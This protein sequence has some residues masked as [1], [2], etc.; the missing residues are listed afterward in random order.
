M[1]RAGIVALVLVFGIL[2]A[3][4]SQAQS[5]SAATPKFEVA[6]IRVCGADAPAGRGGGG[7]SARDPGMLRIGCQ[8]VEN[9]IRQ[10]YLSNGTPNIS[11]RFL[12]QPIKGDAW[13]SSDRYT[14][15]A[16]PEGT[17]TMGMMRGPMMRA[18]LEDRFKLKIHRETREIPVYELTVAKGGPKLQV[19]QPGKCFILDRDHPLV[20]PEPGKREIPFCGGLSRVVHSGSASYAAWYGAT[21]ADLCHG[22]SIMLD[23]DAIDKTGLAGAFDIHLETSPADLYPEGVPAPR[24]PT[25]P[26][27]ATDPARGP[28]IFTALQEQLGLKLMPARA[29]ANSSSSITSRNPPRTDG[30]A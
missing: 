9:L 15:E 25:A 28:S 8:T 11:F 12:N 30:A 23:R 2:N 3:S 16:K 17:Q 4:W 5:P 13:I 26:P 19:A 10:A 29:P 22:L 27:V 6:S 1:T 20:P 7:R 24:D 21:M 18:L 14:I